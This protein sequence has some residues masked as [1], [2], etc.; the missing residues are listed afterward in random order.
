MSSDLQAEGV[1][2]RRCLHSEELAL[3]A[4]APRR[5]GEGSARWLSRELT[6][7]STS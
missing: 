5:S 7:V 2:S 4:L 1:P 6:R 3:A